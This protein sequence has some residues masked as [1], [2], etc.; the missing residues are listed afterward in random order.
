VLGRYSGLTEASL[1]ETKRQHPV[2]AQDLVVYLDG[3]GM[4]AGITRTMQEEGDE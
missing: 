4:G 1:E 3:G 2:D